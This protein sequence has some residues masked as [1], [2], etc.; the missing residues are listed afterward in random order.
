MDLVRQVGAFWE[1][2][3]LQATTGVVA[4]SGGPDS[5]A[6]AHVLLGMRRAGRLQG[7]VFAHLNHQ[8]RG[9]DS[10]ADE[11]FVRALPAAWGADGVLCRSERLDIALLTKEA[12]GNLEDTARQA[13]YRW[14]AEVARAEGATWVATGHTA[15]DQAETVLF[16]L[17]RG[18]GLQ[19]LGGMA[20]RRPLADGLDLIRPFLA[21]RRADVM[22]Y[23]HAHQ[24]AFC[25]DAS[26]G[27][28]RLSRNR[29]R[30]E[31]LPHLRENYNPAVQD[32]LC[33]LALQAQAVQA[34]L[35]ERALAL[36]REAELPRGGGV[37]VFRADILAAQPA[38]RLAEVFRLVWRREGWPLDAMGYDAWQRLHAVVAQRCKAWEF[39]GPV[40]ARRVGAV[41]QLHAD[42][43]K[44]AS[45]EPRTQ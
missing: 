16:R 2:Q 43:A 45:Q 25:T 21:S 24:L 6:L 39:P 9:A 8:L 30:H 11:A 44:N 13:R 42:L 35:S 19:G 27:D 5:V 31:L 29:L 36:L 37:L 32:V 34:E 23:L 15:D 38:H 17:L 28:L 18:S 10:A 1:E 41:L 40:R 14:L 22:Q 7:L 3:Q 12:G 20:P 4:V 26:N 33:R